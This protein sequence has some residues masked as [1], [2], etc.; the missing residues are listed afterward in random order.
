MMLKPLLKRD[1]RG[2]G[3]VEFA[4]IA[5]VL[6]SFIVGVSQLGRMFYANADMKN[7]NAHAA[8]LASIYRPDPQV[9][10][11]TLIA[12][13]KER[14]LRDGAASKVTVTVIRGTDNGNPYVELKTDYSVPLEFIFFQTPPVTLHDTRRVYTQVASA[15]STTITATSASSSTSATSAGGTT[16]ATSASS[17]TSSGVTSSTTSSGVTSSTTSSGVTSSTT[18]STS[19][20]SSGSNASSGSNNGSSGHKHGDCKNNCK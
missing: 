17:T 12:A 14:L 11:A 7:A 15:N 4:L 18:S 1:D 16:S 20:T 19:S 9:D 6:I 13:V 8:R 10:D 3:A 2:I 5:P